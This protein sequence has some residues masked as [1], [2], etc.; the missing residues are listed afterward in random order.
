MREGSM[1]FVE[2]R[3]KRTMRRA[4]NKQQSKLPVGERGLSPLDGKSA[5]I[6]SKSYYTFCLIWPRVISARQ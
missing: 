1:E 3:K 2:K 6:R 4:A 5:A